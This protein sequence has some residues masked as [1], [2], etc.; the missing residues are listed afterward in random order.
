MTKSDKKKPQ[1]CP[2]PKQKS[3]NYARQTNIREGTKIFGDKGNK[4]LLKELN[5]LHERQALL[6]KSEED[7]SYNKKN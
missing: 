3:T 4:A 7:M 2:S 1:L 6:P 5:Q